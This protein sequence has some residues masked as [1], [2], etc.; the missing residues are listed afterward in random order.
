MFKIC[1]K[2]YKNDLRRHEE[3][4]NFVPLFPKDFHTFLHRNTFSISCQ[5]RQCLFQTMAVVSYDGV[6]L[7]FTKIFHFFKLFFHIIIIFLLGPKNSLKTESF[8]VI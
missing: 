2:I 4:G 7:H 1:K 5:L 6:K 8:K 3:S